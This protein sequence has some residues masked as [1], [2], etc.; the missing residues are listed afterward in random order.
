[1][2]QQLGLNYQMSPEVMYITPNI[3]RL[4]IIF[5]SVNVTNWIAAVISDYVGTLIFQLYHNPYSI[6]DERHLYHSCIS[7]V[8]QLHQLTHNMT[9]DCSL[10]YKFSTW[11]LQAHNL[12]CVHKLFFVCLFWNSEQCMYATC[13]E[14]VIFMYWA[15]NS[16]SNLLS[17]FGLVHARIIASG[18]NLPVPIS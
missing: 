3:W 14:L 1:M 18:K 9:K 15:C 17:Y 12:N 8:S 5:I 7:A 10:N 11:K 6:S 2:S 13:S 16:M 4:G